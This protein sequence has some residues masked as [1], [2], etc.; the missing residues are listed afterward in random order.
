M[1]RQGTLRL[2]PTQRS[3]GPTYAVVVTVSC[4]K[5]PVQDTWE[6]D[7]VTTAPPGPQG[8]AETPHGGDGGQCWQGVVA[9]TQTDWACALAAAWASAKTA[10]K[11]SRALTGC[12]ISVPY[13]DSAGWGPP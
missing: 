5:L 1:T 12:L 11:G 3:V 13:L 2:G 6:L 4:E 10:I 7:P 9:G 8:F